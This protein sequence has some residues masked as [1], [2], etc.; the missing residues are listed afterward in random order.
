MAAQL[1]PFHLSHEALIKLKR[2]PAKLPLVLTQLTG[3]PGAVL[4]L[5]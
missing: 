5:C 4:A 3:N 2:A 1:I